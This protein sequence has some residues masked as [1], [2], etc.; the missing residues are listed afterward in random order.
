MLRFVTTIPC[1]LYGPILVVASVNILPENLIW[2][3]QCRVGGSTPGEM[4]ARVSTVSR[5]KLLNNNLWSQC[6]PSAT[7]RQYSSMNGLP[8]KCSWVTLRALSGT[9]GVWLCSTHELQMFQR[10][11]QCIK[12]QDEQRS[13][14]KCCL[15]VTLL[16]LVQGDFVMAIIGSGVCSGTCQFWY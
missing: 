12:V 13:K 3:P 11:W 6:A 5:N 15:R 14:N 2:H 8:M 9:T 1:G 7:Q 4:T 16:F 10:F